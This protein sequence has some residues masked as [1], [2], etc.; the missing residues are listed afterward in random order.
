M[1]NL[2]NKTFLTYPREEDCGY[3]SLKAAWTDTQE[4]QWEIELEF[5]RA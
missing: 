4:E 1:R 2:K 3:Q 5:C